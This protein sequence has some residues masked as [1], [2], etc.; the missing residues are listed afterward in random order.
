[1]FFSGFHW[2][3]YSWLVLFLIAAIRN[4]LLQLTL[5]QQKGCRSAYTAPPS[6]RPG[7]PCVVQGSA[8]LI[9]CV[10]S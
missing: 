6:T 4:L 5:E 9:S 10:S 8:V 7:Q 2:S 3:L 1:M